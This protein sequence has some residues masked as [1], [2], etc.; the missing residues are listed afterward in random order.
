MHSFI[1]RYLSDLEVI[2]ERSSGQG[3]NT[4]LQASR[5]ARPMAP[6]AGSTKIHV[7]GGCRSW[8]GTTAA[9]CRDNHGNYLGSSAI[10]LHGSTDP[11]TLE[12]I[13]CR[14]ALAL[15]E[16][17]NI[18]RI[19]ISSDSKQVVGD[20]NSENLVRYG[21]VIKEIHSR[22]LHFMCNFMYESRRCNIEAHSLAKHAFSS[23]PGCHVWL[24]QSYSPICIPQTLAF[25]H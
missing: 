18:Q 9:V 20:I 8:G 13:A 7:D 6:P 2:K 5:T 12:T 11:A 25:D 24:G 1:Q 15:A 22:A 4:A 14:E 16:D 17:L 23:G 10:V 19:I 3:R 21:T